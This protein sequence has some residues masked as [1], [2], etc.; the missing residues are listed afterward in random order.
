MPNEMTTNATP[1][2]ATPIPVQE[3]NE[4]ETKHRLVCPT[5]GRATQWAT[6]TECTFMDKY[7]GFT[8]YWLPG[9]G[10]LEVE[11]FCKQAFVG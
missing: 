1:T 6:Y 3:W 7:V 9:E 4:D 11:E 10:A 5:T 8:A 2:N